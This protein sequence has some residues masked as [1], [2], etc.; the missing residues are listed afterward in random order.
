MNKISQQKLIFIL[1][2]TLGWLFFYAGIT[3]V[4]NPDWSAGGYLKGA[5]T[6]S[7]FYQWLAS[8]DVV[9]IVSFVNEWSLT[10]L[11]ISL[12][13]GIFVRLS[14]SLGALLMILYYLPILNFPHVGDH[15]YLVD[16]HI[17]YAMVLIFFAVN[18]SGRFM[19]L[20][21]ILVEKV[22]NKMIRF[23]S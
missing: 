14:S 12:I 16:E 17:I 20:D 15:S 13:L 23:F 3:K 11:G 6:F 18:R 5:Q 21:R 8:P 1:R 10:L 22:N 9:G 2:I 19:G 7:G 4:L